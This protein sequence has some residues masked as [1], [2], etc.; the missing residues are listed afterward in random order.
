MATTSDAPIPSMHS[1]HSAHNELADRIRALPQEIQN[2]ILT[3]SLQ[4]PTTVRINKDYKPPLALH[5]DRASR[6]KYL[7]GYYT[8]TIF[9]TTPPNH[10]STGHLDVDKHG[11]PIEDELPSLVTW[12]KSLS[13]SHRR[14]IGIFHFIDMNHWNDF[15][16]A[17]KLLSKKRRYARVH[18]QRIGRSEYDGDLQN[19]RV[20]LRSTI[21]SEAGR[22]VE[23]FWEKT[24]VGQSSWWVN[25]SMLYV[26]SSVGVFNG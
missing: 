19:A 10:P 24:P 7:E 9:E 14:M 22:E 8:N 26:D 3:L 11:V 16:D 17:G 12:V 1:A 20:V 5:L 2:N 23:F 4:L 21:T 13:P 15:L 18:F 6:T 25:S